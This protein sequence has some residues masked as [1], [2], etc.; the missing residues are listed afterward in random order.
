M[1]RR[2]RAADAAPVEPSAPAAAPVPVW[3]ARV[4]E[5]SGLLASAPGPAAASVADVV[6]A[7]EAAEQDHGRLVAALATLDPDRATQELKAALREAGDRPGPEQEARIA[8]L[9]RRHDSVQALANRREVLRGAIDRTVVDLEALA[10]SAVASSMTAGDDG[11]DL[12]AELE[13]VRID[14]QALEAARAELGGL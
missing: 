7:L 2:R 13:R 10:A 5:L 1:F 6:A 4:D 12:L 8:T 9:R 3:R 11:R 14:V